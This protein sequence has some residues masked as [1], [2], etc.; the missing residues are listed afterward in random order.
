MNQPFG[1]SASSGDDG[2][3]SS[4]KGNGNSND[5]GGNGR[6]QPGGFGFGFPGAG[7]P[8]NAGA[9]G[10]DGQQPPGG[11][12]GDLGAILNQFGQMLGSMGTAMNQSTDDPVNYQ[13]AENIA[14]GQL[15][16]DTHA[17]EKQSSAVTESLRLAELWLDIGPG[18]VS[19]AKRHLDSCMIAIM[20][21]ATLEMKARAQVAHVKLAL[22]TISREELARDAALLQM[23]GEA[24]EA[25]GLLG[26]RKDMAEVHKLRALIFNSRGDYAERDRAAGL[27]RRH[28]GDG[29]ADCAA[30]A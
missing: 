14:L 7:G 19:I 2:E 30:V 5:G 15:A 9:G 1:F 8:G 6:Q 26:A 11:F 13:L 21:D 3:D 27:F 17:T 25:Y 20:T 22:M 12:G 10:A 24:A 4:G 18:Y 23:L 28:F 29:G 16:K